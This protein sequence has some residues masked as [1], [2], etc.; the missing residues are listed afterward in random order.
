MKAT[1]GFDDLRGFVAV[2]RSGSFTRAADALQTQKAH[3][4]RVCTRLETRLKVR[5]LQRSTRSLT[6]TEAGRELYERASTILS[7]L[8]ETESAME[9]SQAAPQGLLRV[10]CGE[11]FGTLVVVRWISLF[12]QQH[13]QVNVEAE[14]TNRVIDI[15]HEGFDLAVRVGT[16]EHSALSA[17]KLGEV[18]YGFYASPQYLKGKPA[19][20]APLQLSQ[21]D[22]VV[23]GASNPS[24]HLVRGEESVT[25]KPKA[26]FRANNNLAVRQCAAGGL[27]IALLPDFQA[28]PLVRDGLLKPVLKGWGR[29]PVPVHA[30]FASSRYL[31]PKVR[32]FVDLSHERFLESLQ[33]GS[34]Q[35]AVPQRR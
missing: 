23:F 28:A 2:V 3:L 24:W 10:T 11:E 14:L 33:Q 18:H 22:L 32:A 9:R 25:F 4:S 16:L 31:S 12:M 19:P 30:V 21:H 34:S 26:R 5:L 35:A 1:L 7:A 29:E 13:P 15:V 17:R 27:G 20:T 6:L 8:E